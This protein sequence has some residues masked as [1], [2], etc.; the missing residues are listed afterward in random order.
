[1]LQTA[2]DGSSGRTAMVESRRIISF[3]P[4]ATEMVY[5]LGLGDSLMGV[6]HECDY[7]AQARSKPVVVSNVLPV[8][9]MSQQEID[10][11]VSERMRAGLSLYR[12]DEALV[13]EIAPDLIL[14]QDLCQVCAPSGN[15][16]T[17][18]LNALSTRPQILW[19]TPKSIDQIFGN[20]RELGAATQRLATGRSA[21]RSPSCPTCGRSR[22][23]HPR[24][25]TG[26]GYSAWNGWT[27]SIA[28]A[29]GCRRWFASPAAST[30]WDVTGR[31][32]SAS[33][34]TMFCR[35]RQRF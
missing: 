30:I 14:T 17:Q 20:L 32:P 27:P 19:L 4:S 6:T 15:E 35:G 25:R 2:S 3:L 11:A 7:P 24:S 28:A 34:G 16:V 21:H 31:I 8:E 18:L 29:T 22:R 23:N 1:M 9:R 13:R 33:R 5:A 26:R 12:V 10:I